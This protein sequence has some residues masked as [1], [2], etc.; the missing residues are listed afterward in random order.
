[1]T[2]NTNVNPGSTPQAVPQAD[3]KPLDLVDAIIALE[4]GDLSQ[5]ETIALFQN[6]INSGL[7]WQLQGTYGRTARQL[8]EAG[9]CTPRKE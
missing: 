9:Y 7:V 3:V 4:S 2:V 1:M 5:D 8:I 6:L